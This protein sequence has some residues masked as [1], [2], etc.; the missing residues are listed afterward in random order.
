MLGCMV[1]SLWRS[2]IF[3]SLSPLHSV[4]FKNFVAKCIQLVRIIRATTITGTAIK[5]R[6]A[7]NSGLFHRYHS[8]TNLNFEKYTKLELH[9]SNANFAT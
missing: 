5:N 3:L 6:A 9:F 2:E 1:F 8:S 4:P 7:K